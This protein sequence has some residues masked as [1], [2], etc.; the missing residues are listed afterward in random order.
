MN[1]REF[2]ARC[3]ALSAS[4]PFLSFL[5]ACATEG[6]L[7]DNFTVN[8]TGRVTI[9]GA[10]APGLAAGCI[11]NRYGIPCQDSRRRRV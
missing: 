5:E 1:R 6:G 7:Y 4:V 9:V 11:L 8:F 3:A 2:M 10:G